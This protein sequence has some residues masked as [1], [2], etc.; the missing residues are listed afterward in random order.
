MSQ[1]LKRLLATC[2]LLPILTSCSLITNR[3]LS[4]LELVLL[5]PQQ[6]PEVGV[7]KHKVTLVRDEKRHSFI[8]INR[9]TQQAFQVVVLMATGQ[10]VLSMQYDGKQFSQQ[11]YTEQQLPSREIMAV[12]QF[13]LWPDDVVLNSYRELGEISVSQQLRQLSRNGELELQAQINE[14][15]TVV[16]HY[17]HQYSV[18]IQPLQEQAQ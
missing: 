17:P 7:S 1:R 14:G 15:K 2:L 8:V 10:T 3:L 4:P 18:I 5:P 12:M 16:K 9:F 6:G 11:S 13:S